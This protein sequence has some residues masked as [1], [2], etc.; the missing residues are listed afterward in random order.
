MAA[1]RG[2]TAADLALATTR[3]AM[4]ALPRLRGLLEP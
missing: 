1:L 4:A 2:I 3:N